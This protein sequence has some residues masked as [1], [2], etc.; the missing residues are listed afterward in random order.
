MK[1]D[2][3]AEFVQDNHSFSWNAETLRSLS[4]RIGAIFN[5][6]ITIKKAVKHLVIGKG[7]N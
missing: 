1:L 5:V 6:A 4:F 3:D 7:M 2:I